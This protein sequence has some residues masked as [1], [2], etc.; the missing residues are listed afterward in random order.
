V[1]HIATRDAQLRKEMRM[2]IKGLQRRLGIAILYVTHD[3]EEALTMADRIAVMGHGK[4][5]QVGSP[6]DVFERPADRYAAESMGCSTF[7]PCEVTGPNRVRLLLGEVT[8]SVRSPLTPGTSG[9]GH[10]GIRGRQV[11]LAPEGTDDLAGCL[12]LRTH[13]GGLS[14]WRIGVRSRG[15]EALMCRRS[16]KRSWPEGRRGAILD[17]E[18]FRG[19]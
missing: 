3:Q 6:D 2:E 8:P 11:H 17:T 12:T 15:R 14:W 10:L 4:V 19:R 18:R 16:D 5:H 7:L 9:R 13:L 1:D